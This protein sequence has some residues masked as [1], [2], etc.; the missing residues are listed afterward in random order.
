MA[1]VRYALL[2]GAGYLLYEFLTAVDL[3]RRQ[4][5]RFREDMMLK[6]NKLDRG[7]WTMARLLG[8]HTLE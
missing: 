4:R 2:F 1:V 3:G 7:P 5:M 8:R 6:T